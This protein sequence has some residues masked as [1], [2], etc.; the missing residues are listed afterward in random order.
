MSPTQLPAA[1]T[2]LTALLLLATS[3]APAQQTGLQQ[4]LAQPIAIERDAP[5][6][7]VPITLRASKLFVDASINGQSRAFIFDTGSPTI[8]TREFADALG[9]ETI[10]RNTGVDANGTPITMD[11][12]IAR[13]ITIGDV[14]FRDVPVLIHDFGD[15]SFGSCLLDGGV[16]GSEILPGSAWRIDLAARR[17]SIATDAAALGGAAPAVRARLHDFGYPHAPIVDY[18][19]GDVR[20]KALFDTGNSNEL[21]LFRRV[22]DSPGVQRELVPGSRRAGR[23]SEGESAGGRGADGELFA[24]EVGELE[25]DG[26]PIG[27]LAGTTRS[28]PPSLVGAGILDTYV[29]TLDFPGGAFLLEARRDPAPRRGRAGYGIA[30]AGDHAEVVQLFENSAAAAAGLRLGDRVVAIGERSLETA[31]ADRCEAALWLADGFDPSAANEIV[32]LREGRPQ[33]IE[34][35]STRAADPLTPVTRRSPD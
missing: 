1:L 5:V 15:L 19:L 12:A 11:V 6:T 13:S 3:R 25:L 35:P 4:R 17:L 24:F 7:S 22:F 33:R 31:E 26:R 2:A 28:V 29:A 34:V 32:V 18:A 30:L 20:D 16:I 9:L 21:V 8:L 10:G 27:P 14:E 23:G